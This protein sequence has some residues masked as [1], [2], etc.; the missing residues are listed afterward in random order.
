MFLSVSGQKSPYIS[1][2][3]LHFS[4]VVLLKAVKDGMGNVRI[5]KP[6][7]GPFYVS[8]VPLDQLISKLGEWSRLFLFSVLPILFFENYD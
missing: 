5:Q 3:V 7:Q 4:F 8:Y 6:E 2:Y 1:E